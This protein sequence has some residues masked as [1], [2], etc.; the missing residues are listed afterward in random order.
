MYNRTKKDVHAAEFHRDTVVNKTIA[1]TIFLSLVTYSLFQKGVTANIS[2]FVGI[3]F[4]WCRKRSKSSLFCIVDDHP[5]S[6]PGWP[7]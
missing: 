7:K 2:L 6:V 5:S 4:L 1:I 3:Y